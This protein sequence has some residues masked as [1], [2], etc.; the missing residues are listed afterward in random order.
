MTDHNREYFGDSGKPFALTIGGQSLYILTSAN[1]VEEMYKNTTTLSWELLVQ[2]LYRWIG[3][4]NAAVDKLWQPPTRK[5]K[6]D[7]PVRVLSPN[8][9]VAEYQRRQLRPGVN[10]DILAASMIDHV[11]S[12][13]RWDNLKMGETCDR[14]SSEKTVSL[15]L[16][17]W[18][19]HAFIHSTTDMYW[20]KRIFEIDPTILETYTIWEKTN[21][22]YVFQIPR[23]FSRDMYDARDKL[24]DAFTG[25]FQLPKNERTDA[26]WFVPIAEEEMR[27]IGS[28]DRD[29]GRAHMLQ[30]WA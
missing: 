12:M 5:Q 25:Y 19:S 29:L 23:L 17:E 4:S 27:D 2:D 9:M 16:I 18:T 21:W 3:F 10:M 30:H 20:G 13:V 24:V 28:S 14:Q 8:E 6:A 26:A 22:K 7:N 11:N 15:S 1:D